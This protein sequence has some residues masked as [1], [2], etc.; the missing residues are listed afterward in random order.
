MKTWKQSLIVIMI[1]AGLNGSCSVATPEGTATMRPPAS[2]P[3]ATLQSATLTHAVTSAPFSKT[4]FSCWPL[5][6]IQKGNDIKG[7]FIYAYYPDRKSLYGRAEANG[8]FV[9][10]IDSFHVEKLNVNKGMYIGDRD[11]SPNGDTLMMLTDA[12]I[13]FITHKDIQFFPLHEEDLMN[14]SMIRAWYTSDG[15]VSIGS[16]DYYYQE[17][18]GLTYKTYIFNPQT[19]DI[20][21]I[22]LFLP[23]VYKEWNRGL[24][25][26]FS[27]N[28]RYVLYMSTPTQG[29][30]VQYTVY[31]TKKKEMVMTIPPQ[32]SNLSIAGSDLWWLPNADVITGEFYDHNRN[33]DTYNYYS[34]SLNGEITQITNLPDRASVTS[35]YLFTSKVW[36]PNQRF[37]VANDFHLSMYIWDNQTETL[38]YPCLPNDA[39]SVLQANPVWSFDGNYFITTLSFP[40]NESPIVTPLGEIVERKIVKKYILDLVNRVIYEMPENINNNEFL[41]L[42]KDGRSNFLGW[43]NWE[44]P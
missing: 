17:G 41:D 44:S 43:V 3:S 34:I 5:M 19:S 42:Y 28:M 1:L 14:S 22:E 23:N 40:S 11:I 30:H 24:N 26:Q 16:S 33:A 39:R 29:D 13:V 35:R 10:D 20:S 27:P 36:S 32:N 6:P 21:K 2:T 18:V 8:F 4:D 12:A 37:L 31:D 15:R 9:W 25:I 38:Y 7:S